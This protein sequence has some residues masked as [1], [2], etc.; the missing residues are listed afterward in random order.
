MTRLLL[1]LWCLESF[2]TRWSA[3]YLA[4]AALVLNTSITLLVTLLV[5]LLVALL[6]ARLI[7]PFDT[8]Y[9]HPSE[10]LLD[11]LMQSEGRVSWTLRM[12]SAV[13]PTSKRTR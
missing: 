11:Q 5:A 13:M 10:L 12:M 2:R 4:V 6:I 8:A 7:T 9:T 1:K 3:G